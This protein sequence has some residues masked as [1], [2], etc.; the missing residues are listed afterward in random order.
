MS[1]AQGLAADGAIVVYDTEYTSWPGAAER[2]WS[3]ANE[4][5][6]IVQIGAV[7]LDEAR[8]EVAAFSA[9]VQPVRNPVLSPYF[10]ELTGITNERL[11]RQAQTLPEVLRRF[12][13]FC[14]GAA[15]VGSFGP[16]DHV[17]GENCALLGIVNPMAALPVFDM[18]GWLCRAAGVA[19]HGIES[20]QLPAVFGLPLP[21]VAHDALADA[22]SL[23]AVIRHL[24]SSRATPQSA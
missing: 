11:R 13:D 3:G 19:P 15:S 2:G 4:Y 6:E 17:I 21:S 23:A 14:S 8:L 20:S 12:C 22:R 24:S 18:R 7:W 5:R 9:L 10:E 1:D 16:D